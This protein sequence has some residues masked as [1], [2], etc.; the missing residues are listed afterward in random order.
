MEFQLCHEWKQLEDKYEILAF[1]GE[2]S[3]GQV[4]KA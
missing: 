2:G 3:F 4:V 1:I